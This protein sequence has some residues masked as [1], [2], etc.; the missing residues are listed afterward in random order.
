MAGQ[1]EERMGGGKKKITAGSEM[2]RKRQRE[3]EF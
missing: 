3:R 2:E 1:L